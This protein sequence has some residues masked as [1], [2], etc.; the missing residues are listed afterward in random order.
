MAGA[1]S[2]DG[3]S[4]IP[5]QFSVTFDDFYKFGFRQSKFSCH[6]NKQIKPNGSS[7]EIIGFYKDK[8]AFLFHLGV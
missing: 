3:M 8:S 7:M 2:K 1:H 4:N 5:T 6:L